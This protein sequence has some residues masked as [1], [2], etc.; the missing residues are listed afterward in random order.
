M[1]ANNSP[2]E[3]SSVLRLEL[4]DGWEQAALGTLFPIVGGGTPQTSVPEYWHGTIP[5]VSSSD[6]GEGLRLVPHRFITAEAVDRSATNLVP[7]GSIVI[8]TRVGLGKVGLAETDLCFSQDCQALLF[9][10]RDFE[11]RF[12]L[13]QLVAVARSFRGQGTTISGITKGQ[14]RETLLRVAPRNEQGRI[15]DAIDSYFTRL[16]KTEA[17]L[18]RVKRNLERYRAS[19]LQAAVEGRLVPTEAEIARSEDCRYESASELLARLLLQCRSRSTGRAR[20]TK[21]LEP[22]LNTLPALPEGWCW[23][24]IGQVFEVRIGATPQRASS[25]FWNGDIPWVS[26]GEVAFCRIS[27]T[28]EKITK[29]GMANSST[30]LNPAGS[31]MIGMI[32]EGKTRGQVAILDIE[33][34]N[35]QNAAA[36]WVSLTPIS[37]EY[38]YYA[39]MK[40]YDENRRRSSGNN[41]PALNKARV[42]A[43]PIPLPPLNEQRRIATVLDREMSRCDHLERELFALAAKCLRLRQ[44][45]LDIAFRGRLVD[46]DPKDEPASV[47]L[48]RIHASRAKATTSNAPRDRGRPHK[49]VKK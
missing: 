15:A 27:S 42:M 49:V 10:P 48:E 34:C 12:L 23:T 38:V 26:S 30:Q 9:S 31:V 32:G 28:R 29:E 18:E 3:T 44:A 39:L 17:T 6:F 40:Q 20:K 37:P 35:N 45:F 11:P 1:R 21:F 47:L 22:E 24:C 41:Q 16:D 4:P 46:Q 25:E 33:A 5:W 8:V 36:I 43:I 2:I 19:V 13:H 14:L 7:A